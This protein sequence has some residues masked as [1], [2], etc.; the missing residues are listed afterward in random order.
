MNFDPE[1]I[2]LG[3]EALMRIIDEGEKIKDMEEREK[4]GFRFRTGE[5]N[6]YVRHDTLKEGFFQNLHGSF[7]LSDHEFFGFNDPQD[8]ETE[9][10]EDIIRESKFEEG[11]KCFRCGV[12]EGFYLKTENGKQRCMIVETVKCPTCEKRWYCSQICFHGDSSIHN[13][14]LSFL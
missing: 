8:I 12:S 9:D 2:K 14:L 1:R 7:N 10:L 3:F 5:L 6:S 13:C 11:K 4:N